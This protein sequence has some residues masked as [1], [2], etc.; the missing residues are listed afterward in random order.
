MSQV[1]ARC[2]REA[3]EK[4]VREFIDHNLLSDDVADEAES[5]LKAGEPIEAVEL[6]LDAGD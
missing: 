4:V 3:G 2:D 5:L 1:P 6:I